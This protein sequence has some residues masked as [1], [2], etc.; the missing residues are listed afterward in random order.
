VSIMRTMHARQAHRRTWAVL[1][2]LLGLWLLLFGAAGC[3]A[4]PAAASPAALSVSPAASTPSAPTPTAAPDADC[5]P[6]GRVQ[7]LILPTTYL[8][9]PLQANVYL[10]PC[11]AAHPSERYPVLYLFHGQ[12]YT[13]DQWI[14]LGAV[15]TADRLIASGQVP[16][17]IIVMP[18]DPLWREP[19][20]YGFEDAVIRDLIPAVDAR[21]RTLP[22][23][24]HRA[25]G[26]LSR[27]SGWAFHFGLGRPDLFGAVGAHS[28]VLFG[29][30]SQRVDDWLAAIPPG[31]LPR[32][33]LDIGDHDN[34]LA[35][36][37]V[38]EQLLTADDIPH[39]WHLNLG[40]HDEAYWSAHV[41]EYLRWYAAGW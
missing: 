6:A 18:Y 13:D 16:P 12:G 26:G 17:F 9:K 34:G 28:V 14:R 31:F 5:P 8:E 36:A 39:E 15:T 20:Q 7:A 29:I 10:P 40:E 33:Y 38:L 30:D 19:D 22:D 11:Y 35:S 27:G 23:R 4:P 24:L 25:V 37:R 3:A 32:I 1:F 41:E 2:G 21:F